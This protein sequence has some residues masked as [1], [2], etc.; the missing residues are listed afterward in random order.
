LKITF[1]GRRNV[2]Y[3]ENN[4]LTPNLLQKYY[5]GCEAERGE[6]HSVRQSVLVPTQEA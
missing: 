4:A 1:F 2:R 5:A 3:W 6:A